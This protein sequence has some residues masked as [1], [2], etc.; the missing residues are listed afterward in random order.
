VTARDSFAISARYGVAIAAGVPVLVLVSMGPVATLV[1]NASI[2][3]WLVSALIGL[4]SALLFAELAGGFPRVN[5]GVAVLAA[6]VWQPRS[7]LLA[8]VVQWSYWLGWCPA[9]AINGLLIGA[10]VQ[11]I[12]FP[13]SPPWLAAVVAAAVMTAS[14]AANHYGMRVGARI[15][16]LLVTCVVSVI[17]LLFFGALAHGNIDAGNLRPMAPPDGW[18]STAGILGIGG[19]LFIAGWSAY[20]AE[21]ALAYA[22]RFRAGVRD[23]VR[24]LL[25]VAVISVVAFAMVPFLLLA[26]VG[27]AGLR[28]EPADAFL[29]LSERSTTVSP[30]VVLGVLVLA[31]VI[32]LNMIAVASSW[33]LHQMSRR[34]DA[35]PF[36]GR[37]NRHGM[38]ANALRFDVAVNLALIVAL[39]ALAGGNSAA[40]PIVLLASANVGYFVSMSLALTA[41][42]INHRR[43]VRRGLLRLRPWLARLAPVLAVLNLALLV[44]AGWAWGWAN[45]AIG[46]GILAAV[47]WLGVRTRHGWRTTAPVDITVPVCW[48]GSAVAVA[49][50]ADAASGAA[51]RRDR[52]GGMNLEAVRPPAHM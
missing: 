7:R 5:G 30:G 27:P 52:P 15:Q 48:E 43:P 38:P 29:M 31:L 41:A 26:V 36:L 16:I 28:A 13:G 32:G 18:L 21:L 49:L 3:V 35:W 24:V 14:V 37:L 47:V 39:T 34:G 19:A 45:I 40:V 11:R 17:G 12:A 50:A 20:G 44:T 8:R 4:L 42:W 22:R 1:G 51:P 25:I 23:A 2:L 46:A 9:Q 33:T 10:Y 6:E